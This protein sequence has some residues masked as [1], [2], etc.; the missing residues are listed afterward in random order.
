MAAMDEAA[1]LRNPSNVYVST[2][3]VF[4]LSATRIAMT[5]TPI[6]NGPLVS[7]HF[8]CLYL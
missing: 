4:K 3:E 7:R 8:I 2:W 5:A 6:Q 1:K